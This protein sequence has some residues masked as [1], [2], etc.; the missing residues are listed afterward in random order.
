[1]GYRILITARSYGVHCPDQLERL[2]KLGEVTR[3]KNPPLKADTLAQIIHEYDA[4]VAGLDEYTASV[5]EKA[6][7]LRILARYGVGLNNVDLKKATELGIIV[8]YTPSANAISVAEHTLALIL[9][10]VKNIVQSNENVKRGEWAGQRE[11]NSELH[12][13][14]L[15][16]IGLGKIGGMVAQIVKALGMTVIAYDPYLKREDAER[17]GVEL[18][19]LEKLLQISDI[20]SIHAPYSH[21]THHM[22]G[23]RELSMMKKDAYIINTAR[24]GLIDEKALIDALKKRIIAGAALDVLEMEPPPPN[25]ELIK[26][27]NVLVTP[28]SASHTR[29]A[30]RR[31]TE[32]VTGDV[33][34]VLRGEKPKYVAN[35]EVLY[36]DNL[37]VK[38]R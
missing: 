36:R 7:K 10:L 15:G 20:V 23:E 13:K 16:I 19:P 3:A 5:L 33:E 28:H 35:P 11:L 6:E 18:L 21:E 8:T 26:M 25:Y 1:M 9:S 14:V 17:L 34:A 38:F 22:I 2:E 31:M 30:V 12:G 27:D 4:I 32:M 37:R 24:G 29:E